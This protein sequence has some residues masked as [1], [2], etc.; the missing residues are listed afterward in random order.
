MR[1]RAIFTAFQVIFSIFMVISAVGEFTF[2]KTVTHSMEFIKMPVHL[3]YLVGVLKILAI[4]D[5]WFSPYKWLKE[6]AG[7]HYTMVHG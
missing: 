1:M 3:L 4:I 6:W 7:L 5:L 2:D